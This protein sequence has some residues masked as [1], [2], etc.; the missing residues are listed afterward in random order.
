VTLHCCYTR[1]LQPDTQAGAL[2]VSEIQPAGRTYMHTV[3]T[4][5]VLMVAMRSAVRHLTPLC[6]M[7]H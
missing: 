5:S 2:L 3:L 4:M 1:C 6:M 7:P